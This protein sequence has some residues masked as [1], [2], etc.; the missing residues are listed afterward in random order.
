MFSGHLMQRGRVSDR[1]FVKGDSLDV[2]INMS[3]IIWN[4]LYL[5][6]LL[7]AYKIYNSGLCMEKCAY[8]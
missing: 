5:L 7:G 6:G 1:R 3:F 8:M 2:M 4:D